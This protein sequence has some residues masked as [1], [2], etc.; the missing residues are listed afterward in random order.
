[1][2]NYSCTTHA[3]LRPT[4]HS[5][6]LHL[7]QPSEMKVCPL[8]KGR[9]KTISPFLRAG[10]YFHLDLSEH[11]FSG[12]ISGINSY[13]QWIKPVQNLLCICILILK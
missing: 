2:Q 13:V 6:V 10:F 11:S 3:I 8:F 7:N 9:A 5:P 12:D 4:Q 1:M